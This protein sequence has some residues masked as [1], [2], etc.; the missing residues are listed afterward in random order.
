[1]LVVLERVAADAVGDEARVG[2][3]APHTLQLL[4]RAARMKEAYQGA[5]WGPVLG[6]AQHAP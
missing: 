3:D 2:P 4:P 5:C 6:R 1:M